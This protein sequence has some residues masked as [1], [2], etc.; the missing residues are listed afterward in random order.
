[1]HPEVP[2]EGLRL[3]DLYAGRLDA[4]K[5]SRARVKKAAERAGLP[6]VDRERTFNTRLAQELGAWA[7]TQGKANEF[8]N[9]VFRAVFAENKNIAKV[10]V[11]MEAVRAAGLPET[12]AQKVLDA[13]AF[14]EVVDFDWAQSRRMGVT[15]V[16]TAVLGRHALVGAQPY[17]AF[18][19]LMKAGNVERRQEP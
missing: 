18:E 6:L 5:E 7:E 4:M 3:E 14:R 12:E 8:H 1:M 11:L 17:Y 16:P 2:E 19:E 10:P 9:A 13:G 15:A